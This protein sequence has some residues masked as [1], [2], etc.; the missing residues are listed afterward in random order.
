MAWTNITLRDILVKSPKQS[1]GIV[2]GNAA[3]PM[4]GVVFDNVTVVPADPKA[5]PWGAKFYHCEGV[6]GLAVHGT[7]P[8]PP[9]FN[10]SRRGN[11]LG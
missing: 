11:A 3:R 8:V 5:K 7:S 2:Y 4:E 10:S 9:C 6:R 1:P